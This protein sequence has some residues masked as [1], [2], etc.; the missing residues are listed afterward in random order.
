METMA[1]AVVPSP[2]FVGQR[3]GNRS[4]L[5]HSSVGHR[6]AWALVCVVYGNGCDALVLHWRL[7]V[8]TDYNC[9]TVSNALSS[10][11]PHLKLLHSSTGGQGLTK[12]TT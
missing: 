9:I 4:G 6:S 7:Q 2:W 8:F 5:G 3:S 11:F 12:A 1:T 10:A